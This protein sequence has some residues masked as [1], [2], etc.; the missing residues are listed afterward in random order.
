M[1]RALQLGLHKRVDHSHACPMC[2]ACT[3]T[4]Y[5]LV[6]ARVLRVLFGL[7]RPSVALSHIL[8]RLLHSMPTVKTLHKCTT[9][10]CAQQKL[11]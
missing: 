11:T 5:M 8:N 7:E 1:I 3:S 6:Y 4:C 10:F 2:M 9:H